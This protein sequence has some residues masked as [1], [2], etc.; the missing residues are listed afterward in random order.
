MYRLTPPPLKS[1]SPSKY[2]P[3]LPPTRNLY[4]TNY[5]SKSSRDDDDASITPERL[6]EE[7]NDR[8]EC[9][10]ETED[11]Q[12]TLNDRD[13]ENHRVPNEIG[14][15]W[16]M[17]AKGVVDAEINRLRS[18]RDIHQLEVQEEWSANVMISNCYASSAEHLAWHAD[19]VSDP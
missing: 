2:G 16:I 11:R 4:N 7:S 19:R 8:A 5:L 1:E 14:H 15:N 18:F 10:T 17:E 13:Q 12:T 9:M 3:S 6:E